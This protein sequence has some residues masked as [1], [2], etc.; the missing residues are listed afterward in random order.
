MYNISNQRMFMPQQMMMG[1]GI[2]QFPAYQQQQ[3]MGQQFMYPHQAQ[4]P[5][6]VVKSSK[7]KKNKWKKRKHQDKEPSMTFEPK[8]HQKRNDNDEKKQQAKSQSGDDEES[9][10]RSKDDMR[11]KDDITD[12]ALAKISKSDLKPKEFENPNDR[13]SSERSVSETD[14]PTSK[15]DINDIATEVLRSR[16]SH[17]LRS[18]LID[19]LLLE[20]FDELKEI[21]S[22]KLLAHITDCLMAEDSQI[23]SIS[24]NWIEKFILEEKIGSK[25]EARALNS[26]LSC[27]LKGVSLEEKENSRAVELTRNLREFIDKTV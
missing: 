7:K 10:S 15:V 27:A 26:A 25:T 17:L 20:R 9:E 23:T 11:F 5:Q 19:P 18:F 8:I 21:N 16:D 6:E 12:I 4:H 1:G 22:I 13:V 24:L 3:I 2:S 14:S